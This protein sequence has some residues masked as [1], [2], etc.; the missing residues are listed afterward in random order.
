MG[1]HKCLGICGGASALSANSHT[2]MLGLSSLVRTHSRT[3]F[4]WCACISIE[5]V[6]PSYP[7]SF[8]GGGD[9][10]SGG[11]DQ[12]AAP[13]PGNTWSRPCL[14]LFYTARPLEEPRGCFLV[15][16]TPDH[17]CAQFSRLPFLVFYLDPVPDSCAD[18]APPTSQHLNPC[19]VDRSVK[20]IRTACKAQ[21]H[22]LEEKS[23]ICV[24][25][26]GDLLLAFD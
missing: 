15:T 8:M 4:L 24:E 18:F 25:V 19:Q 26:V 9:E 22:R 20:G 12:G 7:N 14:S 3:L 1:S 23:L 13:Q 6:L 5:C 11:K 21:G 17:F 2:A 10:N 16:G